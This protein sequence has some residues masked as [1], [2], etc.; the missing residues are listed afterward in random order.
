MEEKTFYIKGMHCPSC[1]VFIEHTVQGLEGVRKAEVSLKN[2]RIIIQTE[3]SQL[4]PTAHRLNHIFHKH[5]YSFSQ[6]NTEK[7][8]G[9][10]IKTILPVVATFLL[11]VFLIYALGGSN[12]LANI[13]IDSGSNLP[14]IFLFGIAAGLSSCAA[15]VGGLLLSVKDSW[16][17]SDRSGKRTRFLPFILF[18]GSRITTFA[19]LGG[20]LGLLGGVLKISLTSA[21]ILTLGI[22][23]VMLVIGFQMI[24]IPWFGK[25][26][27]P[28]AGRLA[29]SIMS[30]NRIKRRLLPITIGALTFFIPCGIPLL[31]RLWH[32]NQGISGVDHQY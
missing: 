27:F 11:I 7:P 1:E 15:L 13:S 9:L 4:M 14:A 30:E 23:L 31:P 32:W 22:S 21:A 3:N 29:T 17:E 5:G 19:V 26:T 8:Q 20:I 24:G 2:S 16:Y 25:I 28:S 10:P 18:N 6:K 12:I